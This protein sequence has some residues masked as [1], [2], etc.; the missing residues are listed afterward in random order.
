MSVLPLADMLPGLREPGAGVAF[1]RPCPGRTL[2]LLGLM[3][4]CGSER[5]AA[6]AA[7]W[8]AAELVVQRLGLA[9]GAVAAVDGPAA[10]DAAVSRGLQQVPGTTAGHGVARVLAE[11]LGKMLAAPVRHC[12]LTRSLMRS[13]AL[14]ASSEALHAPP[15]GMAG[16]RGAGS[17]PAAA[18]RAGGGGGGAGARAAPRRAGG[19]GG[20]RP[21]CAG[22]G[23]RARRGAW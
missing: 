13:T 2:Q 23:G 9:L 14:V 8:P 18:G 16:A 11:Q 12:L 21:G 4:A 6:A 20:A 3:L 17:G 10:V 1:E 7:A 22:A 15:W 5:Q 19:A